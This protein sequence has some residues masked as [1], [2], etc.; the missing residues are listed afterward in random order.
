MAFWALPIFG[1]LLAKDAWHTHSLKK[2]DKQYTY[3]LPNGVRYYIDGSIARRLDNDRRLYWERGEKLNDNDPTTRVVY[4]DDMKTV[5]YDAEE[6][7]ESHVDRSSYKRFRA[8]VNARVF[9]DPKMI[10]DEQCHHFIALIKKIYIKE[11]NQ[12]FYKVYRHYD[13]NWEAVL[14]KGGDPN[15]DK[16]LCIQADCYDTDWDD[17][18][19]IVEEKYLDELLPLVEKLRLRGI[20]ELHEVY[21]N[22]DEYNEKEWKRGRL[23]YDDDVIPEC[24]E[25][26]DRI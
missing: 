15:G 23:G 18:G 20:K 3:L 5:V 8:R 17:H 2:M 4:W 16:H 21:A 12:Y 24:A 9:A 26:T 19:Y 11:T 25:L 1:L 22:V 10:Y 6:W 14:R 13:P 7:V